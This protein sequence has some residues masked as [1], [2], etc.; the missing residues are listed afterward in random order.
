M[1]HDAVPL[2]VEPLVGC[3]IHTCRPP[4]AIVN[5]RPFEVA[6]P[7]LVTVTVAEPAVAT[8]LAGIAADSCVEPAKLVVRAAPF[9]NTV[10]PETKFVPVTVRVN[11]ALPAGALDGESDDRVGVLGGGAPPPPSCTIFPTDGTP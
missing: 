3:V 9:H 6:P 8:S 4:P 10:E 1:A 11:P 7:G 2:T 5:V